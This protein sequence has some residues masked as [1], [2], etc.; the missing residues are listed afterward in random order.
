MGRRTWVDSDIWYETRK[1]TANEQSLYLHL[2]INDGGNIA[3]YYKLNLQHLATDMKMDED[4][5][6]ALLKKKTKYW[7]FD[8]ETEQVLL[9]KYTKYNM[10]KGSPQ[11]K[12][13]NAELALLTPCRLHKEFIKAWEECNGI[14]SAELIQDH[15]KSKA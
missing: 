2:L 3:G 13:L 14:G 4:Q 11:I 10:V 1:L 8:E 15:F 7:M 5:V 6:L 9:P 12:K